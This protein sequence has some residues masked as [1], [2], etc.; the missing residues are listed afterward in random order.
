MF[1]LNKSLFLVIVS[2]LSSNLFAAEKNE[3][4]PLINPTQLEAFMDGLWLSQKESNYVMG[5]VV[6]IVKDNQIIL[7]K[8]YGFS[9]YDK[10]IKVDAA[11][12]LFRIASISKPFTWTAVMQLVEQ[13]KL[14]LD[15]DINSYLKEFQVPATFADPV[16][17]KHLMTHTAGFED[18]VLDLGR[19]SADELLPLGAYLK[20]HLPRR[21]RPV[22][23]YSSYSNHST[24][25]AAHVI[26]A[27]TG[28]S[29]SNYI[30][31]HVLLPL[32]MQHTVARHPMPDQFLP[33]LSKNYDRKGGQW[34]H[35]EFLYWTIYP[36]GMM[37][38]TGSDMAKFMMAHLNE[39]KLENSSILKPTTIKKMHSTLFTPMVNGNNWL[40]GFYERN[41]NQTE[42]FGHGGDLNGFHSNLL[43]FPKQNLGVFISFN[44]EAGSKARTAM[45]NAFINYY[46]PVDDEV[47]PLPPTDYSGR[48][49]NLL[50]LY[51]S[52]RR[53]MSDFSQLTLLE[54][55]TEVSV[56]SDGYL[57]LKNP[58][59][60][61]T[62][63][64][65]ISKDRFRSMDSEA[66]ILFLRDEAG[67]ISNM[68]S[69]ASPV[70]SWDKLNFPDSPIMHQLLFASVAL[71]S[72]IFFIYW[73]TRLIRRKI[74]KV[75]T[76]SLGKWPYLIAWL[77]CHAQL[78]SLIYLSRTLGDQE[79]FYF[80]IPETVLNLLYFILATCALTPLLAIFSFRFWLKRVGTLSERVNYSIVALSAVLYTYLGW[81]WNTLSY[82]F[83]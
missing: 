17:M 21:V 71:V 70:A 55:H 51:G 25:I 14:D 79:P 6:T 19:R 32:N 15:E 35:Q 36:A 76:T 48:Y 50:G 37:S 82:Y 8:G 65:E 23:T 64:V 7:N 77:I 4:D 80:G 11:Q 41:R 42:I 34:T 18:V 45:S 60:P 67:N 16:T 26:E 75:T 49:E 22:G 12:T 13:G 28:I 40:H 24:A 39:G 3:Q 20:D 59:R 27:V 33:N 1:S 5:A 81:Y 61:P 63:F 52:L 54:S 72:L 10:R 38:T 73:P 58:G 47:R 31:R 53:N 46:F 44:S 30:E 43:M 57:L 2:L 68:L 29:W 56:N 74:Y 62:R 83:S 66:E 9:D 78:G 69:S